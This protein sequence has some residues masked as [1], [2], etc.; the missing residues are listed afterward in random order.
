[1][2]VDV[3]LVGLGPA[4][5]PNTISQAVWTHLQ[6]CEHIF[7]P[8]QWV[9][10]DLITAFGDRLTWGRHLRTE[11]ILEAATQNA[12]ASAPIAVLYNGDGR[13]F[14]GRGGIFASLGDMETLL[15]SAGFA[16]K[17]WPGV[18]SVN[19]ALD[20]AGWQ[21]AAAPES[22]LLTVASLCRGPSGADA[23][24]RAARCHAV[25]ALL[26]CEDHADVAF[27]VLLQERGADVPIAIVKRLGSADEEILQGPLDSL[28]PSFLALR[29]PAVILVAQRIFTDRNQFMGPCDHPS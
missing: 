18:G 11:A 25:L 13:L 16:V 8:G 2:K 15:Q 6:R 22:A 1:M 20:A 24:R 14:S 12:T 29:P 23:L 21:L 7:Y 10:D 26:W 17:S 19:A 28:K 27:D 9:N 5:N 3:H 4:N